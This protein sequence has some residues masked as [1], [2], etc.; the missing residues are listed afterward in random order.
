M[1]QILQA[2]LK[3]HHQVIVLFHPGKEM[4]SV[5]MKTTPLHANMTVV[6]AVVMTSTPNTALPVNVL[7]HHQPLYHPPLL[8]PHQVVNALFQ[9]GKE[10]T[11]V[12]MKTTPLDVIMMVVIA[13]VMM[14][15]PNTALP[16]NVLNHHQPY[17]PPPYHQI[18][19]AVP[20][21][22]GKE[23][24]FVMMKTTPLDAIM[25]VVIA[26]VMRSTPNI[27][28]LVNVLNHHQPPL[29]HPV[30]M[31]VPFQPGKETTFV[32]MKTTPLDAIL[33]VVIAVVMMSIPLIALLVN[34][35]KTSWSALSHSGLKTSFVM[36]KTTCLNATLM[37]ALAALMNCNGTALNA[38]A[39]SKN[40]FTKKIKHPLPKFM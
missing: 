15:T 25:T 11:F 19:E 30:V 2:Q 31:T 21:Q 16:V 10:T 36:M 4:A 27:A 5:M 40:K 14:S 39:N 1:L 29:H 22:P 18:M 34:V 23:T 9:H 28:L 8:H 7:N 37:V 24:T 35:L 32:M 13:A 3:P 38:N 6:I 33:M 17:H 12:M 26:V 20:F